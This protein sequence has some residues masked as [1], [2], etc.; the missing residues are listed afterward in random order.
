M[1]QA[2]S[3][4]TKIAVPIDL[5]AELSH[6]EGLPSSAHVIQAALE[7]TVNPLTTHSH[8]QEILGQDAGAT[9]DILRLA[10]SAYFGVRL[11]VKSIRTAASV[12]G[13][14]R[15]RSLLRHLLVDRLHE[16]LQSPL[17]EAQ[18]LKEVAFAAGVVG[19]QIATEIN[20]PE[21]DDIQIGGLIHNM[22]QLAIASAVPDHYRKWQA[23]AKRSGSEEAHLALFGATPAD[24]SRWLLE[25]WHFP[26]LF[27]EIGAYGLDPN[28][29]LISPG[30]RP[31]VDVAHIGI[32]L[33]QSW[34]AG[35][36]F[37]AARE[38]LPEAVLGRIGL[39]DEVLGDIY[40][41]TDDYIAELRA[42]L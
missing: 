32:C 28:N 8:L 39:E 38:R 42:I 36:R 22:S 14:T 2:R 4:R 1:I 35:E 6:L 21:P 12:V 17:E 34:V 40:D 24:I 9:A 18:V 27:V 23:E 30:S 3:S 11:E 37:A 25:S 10:N 41:Q 15:L 29:R 13:L 33:A 5:R 20:G 31:A 26:W 19:R 7:A 16:S